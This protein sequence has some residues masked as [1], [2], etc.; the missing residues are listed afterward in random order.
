MD[1]FILRVIAMVTMLTDHIGWYF[2]DDSMTLTWIGRIA[3]PAYAFLLAE[4]FLIIHRDRDRLNKHLSIMLILAV[5]SEPG[6]DL[7][8]FRLDFAQYM[9]YQS[10]MITLLLGYTG[11]LV[12]EALLPSMAVEGKHI[13]KLRLMAL[14]CAYTLIGFGNFMLKANFNIVGPWLV[15]AFYWYI[16]ASKADSLKGDIWPWGKRLLMIFTIFLLYL[17]LYFWVRSSFGDLTRWLEEIANYSPWIAGHLLAV[18]IISLYNGKLGYHEKWFSI[19]YTI[20]YPVHMYIIAL[21]RM[22]SI[23]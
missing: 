15:V 18:L 4:G 19:L 14:V 3:F 10:N 20:F 7:M 23:R 16:R 5:V 8:E 17:P 13:S 22:L 6:F 2:L 11:M 1:G 21:I 9:E 12:T